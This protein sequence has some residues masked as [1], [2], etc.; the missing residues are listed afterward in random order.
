MEKIQKRHCEHT[1]GATFMA[2]KKGLIN[3]APTYLN[4]LAMTITLFVIA[5]CA[6]V[7]QATK[8]EKKILV[9][10]WLTDREQIFEK[11]AQQ[12]E[13]LTG[14]KVVFE[15]YAPSDAYSQKV[16]AA[17]QTD[18]LPDIYGL[19]ATK[20]DFAAFVKAGYVADLTYAMC[21]NNNEWK[22][23][24]FEKALSVNEFLP[25]NEYQAPPGIYAVPIDVMNIQMLY[26]KDLFVRAG[27]DPPRPP[28]DWKEFLEVGKKLKQAKIEG[29][30]S[31]W[32]EVW[33]IDCLAS[34]YA[35]NIMGEDKVIKTI[36]GEVSYADPDWIKV[37]S[38]FKEMREAGLLAKGVV[39]MVNKTAEQMFANQKAALAFN[40]SWCVNVYRGMNPDLNYS[41]MLP[42]F[43][44]E[45]YPMKIWGGA[46]TSFM[47]NGKSKAT[48]EATD[49]LRWLT[50]KEQQIFLAEQ[51]F[52]LPSNKDSLIA[53]NPILAEFAN[54]MDRVVHPNTLPVQEL[55]RVI[56]VFDKGIQS[57]LIGEKTPEEVALEVQAVKIREMEKRQ[58]ENR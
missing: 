7:P 28:R 32:G 22:N 14:I 31:G 8:E 15:L 13:K 21:A 18:T 39:N 35:F 6:K 57:I 46:G 11:L 19:L 49:F 33:M 44:S 51:T 24:L 38:L 58:K 25:G 17:A 52:N 27:I 30:V 48:L 41:A 40:G 16:R 56:E 12:Y 55:P 43:Y 4:L 53:I 50:Q 20:S 5:G 36:K 2:P 34:N 23:S 29:L 45:K 42:P 26:N 3:Q 1:V 9:W 47:V 54:D 10:H 37:F